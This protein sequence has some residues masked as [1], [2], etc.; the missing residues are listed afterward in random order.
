MPS[1][2]T[3]EDLERRIK[4]LESAKRAL[5][6][7]EPRLQYLNRN[8]AFESTQ[9]S[10][11]QEI[12]ETSL[13]KILR[14][15]EFNCRGIYLLDEKTGALDLVAYQGLPESFVRQ[16]RHFDRDAPR[17]QLVM[18]GEPVY[19]ASSE[20][21]EDIRKD[22]EQ[23]K[24]LSLAVIPIKYGDKI[25][26]AIN[27][28]S[29]TQDNFAR[30]RIETI[31]E[32]VDM[33]VGV[34]IHEFYTQ[35]MLRASEERFSKAFHCAPV[36][37]GISDMDTGQYIE[38][39]QAFC[40]RLGF[41]PEDVIG[42]K[43][44][45]VV[46]MDS[47]FREKAID[48]L[49]KHGFVQNEETVI[50]T[51]HGQPIN[52]IFYA[53]IIEIGGKRFNYASA[54]DITELKRAEAARL[55]LQEKLNRM[56]KMEAL[57]LLAGCVAHDLNNILAGIV[58]YPELILMNLP[59]DSELRT[60][61][62][63]MQNAGLRAAAVVE[64]LLTVARGAATAKTTVNMNTIVRDYLNS[65]EFRRLK[66]LHPRINIEINLD[67]ELL[68]INGSEIH[69][70][71]MIMNLMINATEA[72]DSDGNINISTFNKYIDEPI[73]GYDE[74]SIGEY[75]VL[76][77]SDDGLGISPDDVEK[78]FEPF[79]SKKVMGRSGTGLGL[80]V[81]WNAMQDHGGYIDI[82]NDN[83]GTMFQLYFPVTRDDVSDK[84][85]AV[86]MAQCNGNGE[87]ILVVDDEESQRIVSGEMLTI[88]GYDS[89]AVSSGEAAIEYLRDH[90]VDL[91]LLD[92][93]MIPGISGLETYRRAIEINHGQKAVM[94][95]GFAETNDV[96]EAQRLGAGQ[97]IKKPITLERLGGAIKKE[98][99]K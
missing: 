99:E 76:A 38:V 3:Y 40:D 64:D 23:A 63:I 54:I 88:L 70:Q 41:S 45:E 37:T 8:S 52:V 27:L 71:K 74:I 51:K 65:H 92:M 85:A 19:S 24:I 48:N 39:N 16:V 53:E 35:E 29:Q 1:K 34:L 22:L 9:T 98:L 28:G 79:Y 87:R 86:S 46:F 95:S 90:S 36:I 91:L 97:F 78:I 59:K 82:V 57:G 67:L 26:G 13:S 6:Q 11:L 80:T 72:L 58:S 62:E 84:T 31:K 96:K 50:Y 18:E 47:H 68:N 21:P 30:E 94:C 20:F 10:T 75:A 83:N 93:I 44:T 5:I 32:F 42:K 49:R 56:K 77:I 33:E 2:P 89:V 60:P 25:I 14:L 17:V 73:K 43:S 15:D 7:E 81:V 69:I 66:Q 55:E 61:I 12:L 4:E